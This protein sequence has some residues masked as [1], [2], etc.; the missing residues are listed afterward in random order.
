MRRRGRSA[1]RLTD[2]VAENVRTALALLLGCARP[3]A[4]ELTAPLK[5]AVAQQL[6]SQGVARFSSYGKGKTALSICTI[7]DPC[8]LTDATDGAAA[9]SCLRNMKP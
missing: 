6:L 5:H 8:L 3:R 7:G 4:L 9:L 2:V 1:S